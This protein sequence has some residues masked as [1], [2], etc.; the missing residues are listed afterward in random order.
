M[1]VNWWQDVL[2]RT[3]WLELIA[4][5]VSVLLSVVIALWIQ[6]RDFT[7]RATE[8]AVAEAARVHQVTSERRRELL[9]RALDVLAEAVESAMNGIHDREPTN[10]DFALRTRAQNVGALIRAEGG[11]LNEAAGWQFE[12]DVSHLEHYIDVDSLFKHHPRPHDAMAR[13]EEE[14]DLA[15]ARLVSWVGLDAGHGPERT[16]GV[17]HN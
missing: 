6:R 12:A 7:K 15:R 14:A 9:T 8:A 2:D 16:A 5:F 10:E 1:T 17:R 13:L 11:S 4:A 3:S